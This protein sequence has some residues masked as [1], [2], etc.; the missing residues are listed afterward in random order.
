M[1]YWRLSLKAKPL[2][3]CHHVI[4]LAF[5]LEIYIL[6]TL[7]RNLDEWMAFWHVD[8]QLLRN[9]IERNSLCKVR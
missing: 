9:S 6:L 4:P 7:T 2:F 5:V 3:I 8:G 1:I